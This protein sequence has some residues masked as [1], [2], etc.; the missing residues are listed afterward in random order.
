MLAPVI[1]LGSRWDRNTLQIGIGWIRTR[2]RTV[3]ICLLLAVKSGAYARG[4]LSSNNT[5]KQCG[6]D[7]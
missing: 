1:V 7:A 4:K 2:T 6:V 5:G 3:P